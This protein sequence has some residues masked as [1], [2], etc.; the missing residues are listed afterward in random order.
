M[1]ALRGKQIL[2]IGTGFYDYEASIVERL[3]RHGAMVRT[4]LPA[5]LRKGIWGLARRLSR[6]K[7]EALIDSHERAILR[8][9]ADLAFDYVLVIKSVD[10]RTQFLEELRHHQ[11]NAT[12]I[13]YLWDSLAKMQEIGA[14][15]PYFDRV[16]TFDRADAALNTGFQ[17]RPLFYR[18]N[19]HTA[20]E[21]SRDSRIDLCFVGWLHSERLETIRRIQSIA[22]SQHMSLFIFLRGYARQSSLCS[23]A[24]GA[25]ST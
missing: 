13:L 20:A 23:A 10:L 5:V 17:F 15:L 6:P 21:P 8:C 24:T 2:F 16:L 9:A 14:R 11:P 4:F 1:S 22:R 12:F 7:G 18:D 25:T 19:S 3:T